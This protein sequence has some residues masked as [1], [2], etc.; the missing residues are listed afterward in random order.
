MTEVHKYLNELSPDVINDIFKLRENTC[1]PKNFHMFESR[2]PRTK[3]FGLDNTAYR[4]SQLW[5]NVPK[6][7][8]NLTSF[9]LVKEKIKKVPLIS[10]SCN[11]CRKYIHHVGFI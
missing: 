3:T 7:I 5:K 4:D 2:N 8:R 1:N 9:P 10:C 6:E 11:C